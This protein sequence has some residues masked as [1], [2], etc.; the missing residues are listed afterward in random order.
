MKNII[1]VSTFILSSFGISQT[2]ELSTLEVQDVLIDEVQNAYSPKRVSKERLQT[3]STTDISKALKET[4]GVYIRD[5]DGHGL[6]NNIGLRGTNPDRS[7]K[8][9]LLEDEVLIGPA[10]YSAPA[11]YYTP[12]M[13]TT[14]ELNV[15][16]G[17]SSLFYGPNSIGGAINYKTFS[18]NDKSEIQSQVSSFNT[19]I[20]SLKTGKKIDDLDLQFAYGRVQSDGFKVLDSQEKT[21][22]AQNTALLKLQKPL[23]FWGVDQVIELRLGYADENSKETYLGLTQSDFKQ[24]AYRRYNSSE[25]DQMKWQ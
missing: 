7:K 10:P 19:Q 2:T 4:S 11:A 9:V 16:K 23:S 6:R 24:S 5:E 3:L 13:L 22:F 17:F 1:L 25:L 20:L 21:P 15:Y 12:S 8:V 14:E 18:I